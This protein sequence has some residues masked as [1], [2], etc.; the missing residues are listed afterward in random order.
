MAASP[1]SPSTSTSSI[2]CA[3]A[4]LKTARPTTSLPPA[5]QLTECEDQKDGDLYGNPLPLIEY[6]IHFLFLK[7]FL[8]FSLLECY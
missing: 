3:S 2:S 1:A 4:T 8:I 6:Q 7:M 5:P